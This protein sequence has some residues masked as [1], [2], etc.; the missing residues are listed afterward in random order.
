MVDV[1]SALTRLESTGVL[2]SDGVQTGRKFV[3]TAPTTLGSDDDFTTP[4][5]KGKK[6]VKKEDTP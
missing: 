4:A 2:I 1:E 6:V 3:T 5:R